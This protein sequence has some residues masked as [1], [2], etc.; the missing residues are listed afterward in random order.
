MGIP[1]RIGHGYPNHEP[2]YFNFGL[3]VER[4]CK[5]G[6][7]QTIDHQ[8]SKSHPIAPPEDAASG[9]EVRLWLSLIPIAHGVGTG[10]LVGALIE[11]LK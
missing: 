11:L 9:V 8:E 3:S 5:T 6:Q 4:T 1:L 7:S 2:A 10:V